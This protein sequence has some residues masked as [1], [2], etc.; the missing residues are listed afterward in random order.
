MKS[1][2][3]DFN[4]STHILFNNALCISADNISPNHSIDISADFVFIK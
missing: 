1:T 4:Q 2:V 3:L